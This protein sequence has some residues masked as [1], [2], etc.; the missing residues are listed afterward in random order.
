VLDASD[1]V[2]PDSL[3]VPADLPLESDPDPDDPDVEDVED[4]G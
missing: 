2:P 4:E 3:D 1:D